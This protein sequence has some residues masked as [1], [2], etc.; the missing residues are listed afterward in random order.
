[1]DVTDEDY[2]HHVRGL[3]YKRR[4]K[5]QSIDSNRPGSF[6]D[7]DSDDHAI[8]PNVDKTTDPSVLEANVSA[9][10]QRIRQMVPRVDDIVVLPT[11]FNISKECTSL[12]GSLVI[13]LF[14]L[15][16]RITYSEYDSTSVPLELQP[17]QICNLVHI[18]FDIDFDPNPFVQLRVLG[19]VGKRVSRESPPCVG[20]GC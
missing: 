9:F 19:A 1:M 20:R 11:P 17:N 18:S 7:S 16:K 14:Q 8:R 4:I 12:Y 13:Q 5:K 3:S 2:D 6:Y 15:A 10:V